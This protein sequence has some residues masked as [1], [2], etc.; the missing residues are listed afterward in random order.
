MG[1]KH[2]K[3][4][5]LVMFV[6]ALFT[7]TACK[8]KSDTDS[9]ETEKPTQTPLTVT[10]TPTPTPTDAAQ[11]TEEESSNETTA[12]IS[13]ESAAKRILGVIGERGYYIELVNENLAVGKKTY[14]EFQISDSSEIISPNVLVEKISGELLGYNNDGSTVEFSTHPLYPA[15]G[16]SGENSAFT[17]EDALNKLKELTAETLN[18]AKELDNYTIIFDDWSTKV[19]DAL[20]CY[21]INVYEDMGDRMNFMGRY[22]VSVDGRKIFREDS[23]EEKFIELEQVH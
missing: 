9:K 18:L 6:V 10:A 1:K 8:G 17:K 3:I 7:M 12:V 19:N 4:W 14:Y 23:V 15:D 16:N 2:K 22:F 13:S 20:D 21:G 11:E 5:L